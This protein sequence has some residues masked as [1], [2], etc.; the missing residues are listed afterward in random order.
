MIMLGTAVRRKIVAAL[1][2]LDVAFRRQNPAE[3]PSARLM[4]TTASSIAPRSQLDDAHEV[5]SRADHRGSKGSSRRRQPMTT[6]EEIPE[7][8]DALLR[9]GATLWPDRVF[10][11]LEDGTTWTWRQSLIEASRAANVL[12]AQGIGRDDTVMLLLP[13]GAAW[14][15]AWW[16]T[17]LLGA[18]M[19]SVNPAYKGQLLADVCETIRPR[20]IVTETDIAARLGAEERRL[21][22]TPSELTGTDDT[23]DDLD[24]P[25]RPSDTHCLLM[26]SGTTGP[27]KASITT[28]AYV[29]NLAAWL[30]DGCRLSDEDVFLADMPW[31][32]LSAFAP[33]V[34]MMRVGGKIAVR[35]TPAMS[36]YWN[37]AK[38]LGTT[39]AI[40]PGTVAQFLQ[41]QPP[42]PAE[43]DHAMRFMLCAPLP[44]DPDAFISRFG[45]AGLCTAYG[46]TEANL[47][48]I[49]TLATALRAGSCGQARKG[50]EIRIVDE[51]DAEVPAG[52]VGELIVRADRP[53]VQTQGYLGQPEAGLHTS[54]N[55][56]IHTGDALR[57]DEDGYYFFHDRYKD[58]LRRRGEN[59]SSFEVEREV[60]A[61]PGVFEA[62]CVAHP[63]DYGG[64]DEV[65]IFVV[66]TG[67]PIDFAALLKFLADR[68]TYFMVPR[69]FELTDAL[70]KS[71][72]QR[73][74]K[75]LLRARGNGPTTWDRDAEGYKVTRNGLTTEFR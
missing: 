61:Y 27:S 5:R 10:I 36:D 58:G 60:L 72:T 19:A 56:W 54:R 64:D 70:P 32:H 57:V 68:M 12:A 24:P 11:I 62:A 43:H 26:T 25:T 55:G 74:Q 59:I 53:W 66:S 16:A 30:V 7:T 2:V 18:V 37:T 51:N 39:F 63:G 31:F 34:Q 46:S 14:L 69:F 23:V 6:A 41:A 52:N 45:L 13:N 38:N 4:I 47:V 8:V 20:V 17:A 3:P 50:F 29:C 1:E 15:R 35:S 65:K 21:V 9:R 22:L 48:V 67:G 49:S 40:A 44:P 33:A 71:P 42:S 73:V 75:H 28:H